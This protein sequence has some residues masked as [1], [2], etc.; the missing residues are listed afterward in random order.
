MGTN[1][2]KGRIEKEGESITQPGSV[3]LVVSKD[4][5]EG[6]AGSA[7]C[8]DLLV[9][10]GLDG[11]GFFFVVSYEKDERESFRTSVTGQEGNVKS[12]VD[13]VGK[14]DMTG[15]GVRFA[16]ALRRSQKEGLVPV[17]CFDSL[18]DLLRYNDEKSSYA[19]T[20]LMTNR[21]RRAGGVGHVHLDPG[22]V[23]ETTVRRF[24]RLFD[25]TVRAE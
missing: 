23:G 16:E 18:T 10:E 9:P 15:I 3:T 14:H 12:S 24:E 20:H 8:G 4:G 6:K 11:G 17:V 25:G 7:D 21:L 2:R 19:F 1:I 5:G 13:T 22:V